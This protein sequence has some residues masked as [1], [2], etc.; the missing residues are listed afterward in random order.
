MSEV[1]IS[2]SDPLYIILFFALLVEGMSHGLRI[3]PRLCNTGNHLTTQYGQFKA[4]SL[5][6][7]KLLKTDIEDT[8]TKC[9][10]VTSDMLKTSLLQRFIRAVVRIFAP[11]L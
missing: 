3:L 2:I 4:K 8:L 5:Q 11:M 10:E 6:L 1:D 7:V 9:I